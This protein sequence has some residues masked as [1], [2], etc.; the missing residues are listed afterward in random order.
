MADDAANRPKPI[1]IKDDGHIQTFRW[2]DTGEEFTTT[3]NYAHRLPDTPL[4]D[5]SLKASF[6][7]KSSV[8]VTKQIALLKRIFPELQQKPSAELLKEARTTQCLELGVF[9]HWKASKLV[10]ECEQSEIFIVE[11]EA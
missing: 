11:S 6:S 3:A 10:H 7:S 2:P 5:V 4:R 9:Q 8:P 1:L